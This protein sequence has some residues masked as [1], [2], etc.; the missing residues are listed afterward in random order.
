MYL[1]I[2]KKCT[3]AVTEQNN[4]IIKIECYI[5]NPGSVNTKRSLNTKINHN[6][7]IGWRNS[8]MMNVVESLP[9]PYSFYLK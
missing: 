8:G 6:D 5:S 9:A 2:N 1:M 7:R 3:A 4:L